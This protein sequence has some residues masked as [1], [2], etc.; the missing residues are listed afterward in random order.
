MPAAAA[1][2]L[3]GGVWMATAPAVPPPDAT[4][5]LTE[6][7]E[8]E[9]R[10][11]N[12]DEAARLFEEAARRSDD[13]DLVSKNLYNAVQNLLAMG[14]IEAAKAL[15]AEMA[16]SGGGGAGDLKR[17]YIALEAEIRVMEA[18][19]ALLEGADLIDRSRALYQ[20]DPDLIAQ[21]E[22]QRALLLALKAW[23]DNDKA[24][25]R[26]AEDALEQQT[27]RNDVDPLD[28]ITI[29]SRLR[30]ASG[31]N[32]EATAAYL[33]ANA[34]NFVSRDEH[35]LLLV[36]TLLRLER[37]DH[38]HLAV[39]RAEDVLSR[40][41]LK[42]GSDV[43]LRLAEGLAKQGKS[44]AAADVLAT[45]KRLLRFPSQHERWQ[46]ALF[47]VKLTK[48]DAAA[49]SACME[50]LLKEFPATE[51]EAQM[52]RELASLEI[53]NKEAA[54]A[55]ALL[56]RAIA[57][58][59]PRILGRHLAALDLGRLLKDSRRFEQA[60]A[61]Y[62]SAADY[63]PDPKGW[64]EALMNRASL[65]EKGEGAAALK[66][67]EVWDVVA[68]RGP[69]HERCAAALAAADL[70]TR[71][72]DFAEAGRRLEKAEKAASDPGL[73][74]RWL[75][76]SSRLAASRGESRQAQTWVAEYLE[77]EKNPALRREALALQWR[78]ASI[79]GDQSLARAAAAGLVAAWRDVDPAE[80][81]IWE[82]RLAA[83]AAA[84]GEEAAGRE[85]LAR[86][87]VEPGTGA[88]S[89]YALLSLSQEGPERRFHLLKRRLESAS[90]EELVSA[91]AA[92][93][94]AGDR[95]GLT[96]LTNSL[97]GLSEPKLNDA[98]RLNGLRAWCRLVAAEEKAGSTWSGLAAKLRPSFVGDQARKAADA[99]IAR[100]AA[101]L[102]L[103]E[104]AAAVELEQALAA[105]P[106]A[107]SEDLLLRSRLQEELGDLEAAL[108]SCLEVHYRLAGQESAGGGGDP[109]LRQAV[110]IRAGVLATRLGQGEL[111]SRLSQP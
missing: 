56:R 46:L 110:R 49:A 105:L 50:Q 108:N 74:P 87:A 13:P 98:S 25:A 103:K 36:Q 32:L 39:K 68:T 37:Y 18:E 27:R 54:K 23:R 20:G 22:I 60:A 109:R 21:M 29:D 63:A 47:R 69:E 43:L 31:E 12:N 51:H 78:L 45:C 33:E 26:L 107:D 101:R 92:A 44:D 81:R 75:L 65:L 91:L 42:I 30:V 14:Q 40:R 66:A 16:R 84:A 10:R 79:G 94:A 96:L 28:L 82:H 38:A 85:I 6:R 97:S 41:T 99:E 106:D 83:L 90:G 71:F 15:V 53:E 24:A 59:S 9:E 35:C 95:P 34:A 4:N 55:E 89:T 8:L 67:L 19:G 57:T 17:R 86:S 52:C 102:L 11:H 48:R 100:L 76:V 72:R 70:L 93:A 5:P 1:W 88:G 104:K 2:I 7:A 77:A 73:R 62:Q 58:P 111:A 80:V 3:M 61:A 64:A